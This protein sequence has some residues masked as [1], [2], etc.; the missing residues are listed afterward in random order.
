MVQTIINIISFIGSIA[1]VVGIYLTYRQVKDTRQIAETTKHAVAN[2]MKDVQRT[3]TIVE[4]ANHLAIIEQ[5]QNA[6]RYNKFELALKIMRDLRTSIIQIREAPLLLD[7]SHYITL[8]NLIQQLVNDINN[9]H[10]TLNK[11][12]KLNK[13][14]VIKHFDDLSTQLAEIQAK[15]K[16]KTI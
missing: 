4:V 12:E 3:L 13:E 14:I 1:S 5:I 11:P 9:V 8:S 2:A 16:H 10:E 15:F 7:T 6:I